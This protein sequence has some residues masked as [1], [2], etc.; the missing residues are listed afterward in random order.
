MAEIKLVHQNWLVAIDDTPYASW[1]FNYATEYMDRHNDH[2]YLFNVHDEPTAI[3]GGY[4][5]PELINSIHEVEERRSKK[6]LVHYG[7]KARLLGLKYTMMKGSSSNAGDLICRAVNQYN[8]HQVVTGRRDMGDVKRFFL[9]ST[10]KYIL[11]HANCNVVV[12]KIA[13]GPEEEHSDRTKA[14][15]AEESERIRR[16]IE[17]EKIKEKEEEER[18]VGWRGVGFIGVESFFD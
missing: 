16:I 11:E 17:E 9:G 1:A 6:I 7:H 4:A 14:I 12:V 15:Q 13:V 3:Y 2:L 8:I 10:S 5:T 18:K